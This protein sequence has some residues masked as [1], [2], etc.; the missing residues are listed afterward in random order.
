MDKNMERCEGNRP[1]AVLQIF[2]W[3]D[4]TESLRA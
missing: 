2:S 4:S 3:T 1:K